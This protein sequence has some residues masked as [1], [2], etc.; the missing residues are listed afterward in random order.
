MPVSGAG[1]V[2]LALRRH[3]VRP[4]DAVRVAHESPRVCY[5]GRMRI[6]LAVVLAL[7]AAPA[8]AQRLHHHAHCATAHDLTQ[9][10]GGSVALAVVHTAT[11]IRVKTQKVMLHEYFAVLQCWRRA[12]DLLEIARDSST[13]WAIV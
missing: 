11:H 1:H 4:R 10:L 8:T 5:R 2:Q 3:S 13:C 6:A 9:S 12:V 7:V